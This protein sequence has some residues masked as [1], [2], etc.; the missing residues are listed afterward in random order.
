MLLFISFD[1][2]L[3]VLVQRLYLQEPLLR[4]RLLLVLPQYL[5]RLQFRLDLH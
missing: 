2:L 3:L 1:Q 4:H 5:F